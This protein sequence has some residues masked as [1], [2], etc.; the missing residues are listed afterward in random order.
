[1]VIMDNASGQQ[2]GRKTVNERRRL[3]RYGLWGTGMVL[4]LVF[5]AKCYSQA[6]G[7]V[8]LGDGKYRLGAIVIDQVAR[9]FTVPGSVI[10]TEQPL[11]YLVVKKGGA[12][13]YEAVLD[14]DTTAIE[15]NL[16]CILIGLD[17][18]NAVLPR[19]HFD[20]VPVIGDPVK[21]TITWDRDGQEVQIR[22]EE[23]FLLEGKP[24]ESRD[25]TY[26]GSVM[27]PDN[28]RYL[29]EEAGTLIGFVH[30]RDSIIEHKQGIG[31]G[32]FGSVTVDTSKL[33]PLGTGVVISVTNLK[34]ATAEST[35]ET[36]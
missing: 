34:P 22:P 8:D 13:A 35:Q 6:P 11:E 10:R 5:A 26:T 12:K 27:L 25:W 7:V 17:S 2:S 16:A 23:I 4:L 3:Q 33:P 28:V 24:V 1:M 21:V 18:D 30:D 29:A 9:R 36:N 20:E 15:F 19:H 32:Q 31:L 14:A